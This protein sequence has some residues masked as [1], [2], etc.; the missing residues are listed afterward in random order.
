MTALMGLARAL[1][2]LIVITAG[3]AMAQVP[4]DAQSA[5]AGG[6]YFSTGQYVDVRPAQP[7]RQVFASGQ[8]VGVRPTQPVRQVF[9][10]GELVGVE[11]VIEQ[12]VHAAGRIVT[13]RSGAG[14]DVYAAGWNVSVDGT[15]GGDVFA[16]GRFVDV[17]GDVAGGVFLAGQIVEIQGHVQGDAYVAAETL[18]L[19]PGAH[20]DGRLVYHLAQ[21]PRL[22]EGAVRPEAIDGKIS[23]DRH[24]DDGELAL[25]IWAALHISIAAL[26]LLALALAAVPTMRAATTATTSPG[27][28]LLWGFLKLAAAILAIVVLSVTVIGLPGAII[29]LLALPYALM[30]AYIVGALVWPCLLVRMLGRP[31]FSRWYTRALAFVLS[32]LVLWGA[33]LVPFVGVFALCMTILLGIGGLVLSCRRAMRQKAPAPIEGWPAA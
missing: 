7:T 12:D 13:I 18:V 3:A 26:G 4:G 21:P 19:G 33:G 22:P 6:N 16:A 25:D 8:Y 20:I 5:A 31:P 2:A 15:V 27:R 30:V 1:V 28:A 24:H 17:H 29:L 14:E 32:M 23:G 9:A 11:G 10:A